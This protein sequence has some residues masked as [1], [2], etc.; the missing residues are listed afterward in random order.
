MTISIHS[1]DLKNIILVGDR[2]LVKPRTGQEKTK[3]GL[4]LPPGVEEK[5][6]I[7]SGYVVKA[8]PGYPIPAINDIDEPWKE[9]RDDVKY[10]PLQVQEGDLAVFLQ[11]STWEIQFNGETYLIVPHAAILLLVRDEHLYR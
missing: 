4:L 2:V 11:S 7:K 3:S 5:E 10:V 6:P 8:G 1:D 9:Q